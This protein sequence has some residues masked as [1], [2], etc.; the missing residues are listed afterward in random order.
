MSAQ[1][2]FDLDS[3][4]ALAQARCTTCHRA[5][6]AAWPSPPLR[7]EPRAYTEDWAGAFLS[8]HA[9]VDAVQ[10]RDLA[11]YLAGIGTAPERIRRVPAGESARGEQL[12]RESGCAL[13]HAPDGIEGL[14][15]KTWL[16]ALEAF[17]TEPSPRMVPS[18]DFGFRR[19]ESFS[20]AAFLLRRQA[21]GDQPAATPGL[22]VECYEMP[23]D[24]GALPTLEGIEPSRVGA[25]TRID[26][27]LRTRED[28]F[29]LRFT[30]YLDV[31]AAGEW[32][33]WT[34]SDDSSWL[35]IDGAL[36]VENEGLAPHRRREGSAEL[37]A[38]LHRIE[39]IYLE[40]QGGQSLEVL[41]KGPGVEREE[42][43]ARAMSSSFVEY[44]G[45]SVARGSG[46]AARGSQLF[47]AMRCAQCH[48]PA[49]PRIAAIAW[50]KLDPARDCAVAPVPPAL[51]ARIGRDTPASPAPRDVLRLA[52]ARDACTSCHAFEGTGAPRPEA[53]ATL[54]ER[55]DLGDE[56]RVPPALTDAGRE[57]RPEWIERVLRGDARARPYLAVRKP[58]L[59]ADR[60]RT[61]ADLLARLA[62]NDPSKPST[63]VPPIV[64]EQ[65]I[66]VGRGLAG[67]N[68]GGFACIA[69]HRVAGRPSLGPQG[70]DLATQFDRLRADWMREWI[71]RPNA[72]R[73]GTRMPTFFADDS[74]ATREK[75]DALVAW[76]ALGR[77]LPLPDGIAADSNPWRLS[78]TDRPRLHGAF[79]SGLSARCIAVATPARVNWAYDLANARLAWLWRGEFLDTSGTWNGRAGQL[80]S[81]LGDDFVTISRE[82]SFELASG[83]AATPKV[84]GWRLDTDG[85]PIFRLQL[86]DVSIEDAPRPRLAAGGAVL[87]R[88]VT[89]RG[90]AI[91]M[92]L[93]V[94]HAALR[95]DPVGAL[96]IGD[97]ETKEVIYR[98]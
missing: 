94:G 13:C 38:G 87:V 91:R 18:H 14:A 89:A 15:T 48:D 72:H 22:R 2:S 54:V 5:G 80:L 28:N 84:A 52:M 41:W 86:G 71:L 7:S 6:V 75:I 98:W 26:V 63:D 60:A 45:P 73:P 81:P 12:W 30:G 23:I 29:V 55:E 65:T 92:I 58:R 97:G 70:M 35:W 4:V 82:E 36:V 17:L 25:A 59:S 95:T 56:G 24:S 33:F 27:A 8:R 44:R 43:P 10:A 9:R 64:N 77:T 79:L 3:E 16:P 67:S 53:L 42:I 68:T 74:P 62:G 57:L 78:V 34:G 39:V 19:D 31:P 47:G 96:E 83:A 46:D 61:Y 32:R 66:A 93:P 85:H 50:A 21:Q 49:A 40:A 69:C 20:L 88:R 51:R 90:G 11:A 37:R 76:M 1:Q